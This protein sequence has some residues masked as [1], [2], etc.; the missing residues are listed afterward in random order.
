MRGGD[1]AVTQNLYM[2]VC[3]HI[4]QC[5]SPCERM[6]CVCPCVVW[7]R[8]CVYVCTRTRGHPPLQGVCV[9]SWFPPPPALFLPHAAPSPT[10][11]TDGG[12]RAAVNSPLPPAVLRL[13]WTKSKTC[14]ITRSPGQKK[15]LLHE[16]RGTRV[17]FPC[18]PVR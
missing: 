10:R 16:R 17:F 15:N 18:N 6:Q 7:Y 2:H 1:T 14:N 9:F 13:L 4:L 8:V 5:M 3:G 11:M 12:S